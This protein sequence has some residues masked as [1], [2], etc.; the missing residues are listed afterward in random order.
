[1]QRERR[2]RRRRPTGHWT[3]AKH[4]FAA[5]AAAGAAVAATGAALAEAGLYAEGSAA[6]AALMMALCAAVVAARSAVYMRFE[7]RL[8]NKA[9]AG[10]TERQGYAGEVIIVG[11]FGLAM[12]SI[13]A[14]IAAQAGAADASSAAS[15]ASA[16]VRWLGA[17][18][19][20]FV[21]LARRERHGRVSPYILTTA[22]VLIGP[23]AVAGWLG[24]LPFADGFL[25]VTEDSRIS[26][27]GVR[28]GGVLQYPNAQGALA[29][30]L[31][32]WVLVGLT[33]LAGRESDAVGGGH[34]GSGRA[35]RG[36]AVML[37][38]PLLLAL[39]LSES[40]GATLAGVAGFAV[41]ALL[42]R[43]R[44]L[45]LWLASAGWACACAALAYA[46]LAGAAPPASRAGRAVAA[47]AWA[48]PLAGR[49]PHAAAEALPHGARF[50]ALLLGLAAGAAGL[51][52]LRRRLLRREP[53][54]ARTLAAAGA[55]L[56]LGATALAALLP[57]ALLTR[58]G[59]YE[60][61]ASRA[62]MYGEALRLWR[63]APLFGY[64]GDAWRRLAGERLGVREVH[65]GYLD[66][67]LDSGLIGL[68]LVLIVAVSLLLLVWRNAG[69]NKLAVAPIT[70]LLLHAA[71]DFDMSYGCWW[72]V[73]FSLA[74][75]GVN[76]AARA[77]CLSLP[78]A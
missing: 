53:C 23:V 41:G 5:A 20:A 66:V 3:D 33:E 73:L 39:L 74:A 9:A 62:S 8:M 71:I 48:A 38:V 47:S 42:L 59:S 7:D 50:A 13:A 30:A 44:R 2:E 37:A 16:G 64:G 36:A 78:P 69:R 15:S 51:A 27:M 19:L 63:E 58:G 35:M 72:L 12:S 26:S 24:W 70:A 61:A 60:T 54:R 56:G 52:A 49:A 68:T 10:T 6:V 34:A 25:M 4:R 21:L 75:Y 31:L 1:M 46:A 65:S 29:A 14:A 18:G 22:A 28:L 57:H 43:G 76:E 40:R 77:P 11:L 17:A 55:L 45:A 67:L 32:L